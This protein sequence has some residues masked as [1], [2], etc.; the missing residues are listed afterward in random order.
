VYE[1]EIGLEFT[2][3]NTNLNG[4]SGDIRVTSYNIR[5][6]KLES[7]TGA[8]SA[9]ADAVVPNAMDVKLTKLGGV[10]FVRWELLVDGA[11]KDTGW[12]VFGDTYAPYEPL[13]H[14]EK[15]DIAG[16]LEGSKLTLK[17][18]G[19]VIAS[20]ITVETDNKR[21]AYFSDGCMMLLPGEEVTVEVEF[22]DG[23]TPLYISGFGVP[24]QS[25]EV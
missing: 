18:N 25:L 10:I 9:E 21:H 8:V 20:A 14:Q 12:T 6:E 2:L 23:Q 11:V 3:Y 5:G 7:F 16:K 22:V 17:N 1:K 24:Y 15:C 19:K 4:I 13:V